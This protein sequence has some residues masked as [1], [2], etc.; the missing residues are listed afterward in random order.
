MTGCEFTY[1]E[2]E[3]VE[4]ALSLTRWVWVIHI[5]LSLP[6]L[7]GGIPDLYVYDVT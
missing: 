2:R 5:R 3:R 4:D 7:P 1:T 6:P